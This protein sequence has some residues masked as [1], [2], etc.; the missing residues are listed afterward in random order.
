MSVDS[1]RRDAIARYAAHMKD[2]GDAIVYDDGMPVSSPIATC[3]LQGYL[4]RGTAAHGVPECSNGPQ[5]RRPSGGAVAKTVPRPARPRI[6]GGPQAVLLTVSLCLLRDKRQSQT[7]WPGAQS[8][9]NAIASSSPR[10]TEVSAL[11]PLADPRPALVVARRWASAAPAASLESA[12]AYLDRVEWVARRSPHVSNHVRYA[13]RD[14][15]VRSLSI[16][17]SIVSSL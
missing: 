6:Q 2:S 13:A 11:I 1:G 12:G 10:C 9:V 5:R 7:R 15:P 16:S 8:E 17:R 14:Y 3:E 4:V